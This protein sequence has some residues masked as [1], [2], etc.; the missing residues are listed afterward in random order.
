MLCNWKI[1]TWQQHICFISPNLC[2]GKIWC[3]DAWQLCHV[4]VL[5]HMPVVLHCGWSLQKRLEHYWIVRDLHNWLLS[6]FSSRMPASHHECTVQL[7][8]YRHVQCHVCHLFANTS[9]GLEFQLAHNYQKRRLR[10]IVKRGRSVSTSLPLMICSKPLIYQN[11]AFTTIQVLCTGLKLHIF[12]LSHLIQN[13][14]FAAERRRV[15]FIAIRCFTWRCTVNW[16]L[17][18]LL[19]PYGWKRIFFPYLI[20]NTFQVSELQWDLNNWAWIHDRPAQLG[21]SVS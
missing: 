21:K 14:Q 3:Y 2:L 8:T 20:D 15:M 7:Y 4:Q 10:R 17:L 19:Y 6:A 13:K 9:Q 5:V 11:R 18:S 1:G 12:P 16:A